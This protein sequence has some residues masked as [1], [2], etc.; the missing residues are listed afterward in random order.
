MQA[1]VGIVKY[2]DRVEVPLVRLLVVQTADN[3]QFGTTILDGFFASS[4]Y[5]L[6]RHGIA[7]G[8]AQIRPKGAKSAT[9]YTDIGRVQMRVDVVVGAIPIQSLT[10]LIGQFAECVQ[11]HFRLVEIDAIIQRKALTVFDF[12]SNRIELFGTKSNHFYAL[13]TRVKSRYLRPR[14]TTAPG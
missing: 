2:L 1:G 7:F 13:K 4:Q 6:V 5:L 9:I 11:R 8:I 12:G 10:Y 3:M 14:S